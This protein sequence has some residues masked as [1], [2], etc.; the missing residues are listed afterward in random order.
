MSDPAGLTYEELCTNYD[1]IINNSIDL[2]SSKDRTIF[3]I[4]EY[5][6][7]E[8]VISN[9]YAFFFNPRAEH[10]LD[11]LFL[12]SLIEIIKK[13]HNSDFSMEDCHVEREFL[14]IKRGF[15]DLVL[16][17][18]SDE[19][20]GFASAIIIENKIYAPVKNNLVDYYNS[21]K[22]VESGQKV[23]VV[24]SLHENKVK[25]LP[26]EFIK[27]THEELSEAIQRNL[28]EYV[29][30]AKLKYIH[31]LQDFIS[32]LKQ[33]T[34]PEEMQ[35]HIK[36]YFDNATKIDDLLNLKAQAKNYLKENLR[37]AVASNSYEWKRE[38]EGAFRFAYSFGNDYCILFY[39]YTIEKILKKKKFVLSV[40]LNGEKV[41]KHWER[42]G[43]KNKISKEKYLQE[44]QLK[45][46]P[47]KPYGEWV[48]LADKKYEITNI[49]NFGETVFKFLKED[50][51]DFLKDVTD[52][53]N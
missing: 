6:H 40:W 37:H 41:V 39:L 26:K 47:H 3:D 52:I 20:K 46:F 22:V 14:T 1:D 30:S 33:M 4:S 35:D 49:E 17:E 9:W 12:K 34:R 23:G 19:G 50:W 38:H 8:E 24:L 45:L 7:Y 15:I 51:S 16:Y 42:V 43:G 44:Y 11:G 29:A 10:S 53:L 2:A 32:N 27:I 13:K 5:P 18:Q 48:N 21:V 28:G 25:D 31:T 36:Y